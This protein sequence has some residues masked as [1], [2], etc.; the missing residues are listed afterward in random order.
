MKTKILMAF[1]A[2]FFLATGSAMA[3]PV[4]LTYTTSQ[5]EG[6]YILDFTVYNNTPAE[7]SKD[8]YLFG[9]DVG[10]YY[11]DPNDEWYNYHEIFPSITLT[12]TS[13]GSAQPEI[14]YSSVFYDLKPYSLAPG[15]SLSGFKVFVTDM[16]DVVNFFIRANGSETE[17][18]GG[19]NFNIHNIN[20]N[21]FPTWEGVAT[22]VP[23]PATLILLGLGFLGIIGTRKKITK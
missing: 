19:D 9:V 11:D 15:E 20:G 5:T 4:D 18:L 12:N 10:V 1:L 2:V 3:L 22:S 13:L 8:V 23:E 16:P 17:Y 7:L 14:T 6:G 21:K